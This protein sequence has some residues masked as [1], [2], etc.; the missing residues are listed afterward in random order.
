M[1][2]NE[3]PTSFQE[4]GIPTDR[5]NCVLPIETLSRP[6]SIECSVSGPERGLEP[7]DLGGKSDSAPH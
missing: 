3:Q 7:K 1:D 5:I 6:F 4:S 2:F